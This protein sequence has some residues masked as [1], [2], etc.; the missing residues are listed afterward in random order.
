MAR[1]NWL[2]LD[3]GFRRFGAWALVM[4]GITCA[5]PAQALPIF[6]R[7]TQLACL[8]CHTVYPEL[9]HFGRMFKLNGYQLDN[10]KDITMITDE[11]KQQLALPAVPNLGLFVML[12]DVQLAKSL[13]DSN[14]GGQRSF[15]NGGVE[16]PQQLSLL[17]GGKIAPHFGAFGQVTYDFSADTFNIDNNDFRFANAIVLPDKKPFTYGVSINNNPTI[18]DPWNTTPAFGFPYVPPEVNVPYPAPIINAGTAYEVAGPVAY[19]LWNEQFYAALGV[20]RHAQNGSN[21]PGNAILGEGGPVDSATSGA[22]DGWNP[23]W[24]LAYEYDFDRYTAEVGTYG[25]YFKIYPGNGA[26]LS[27]ATNN[28]TDIAEDFQFQFIGETNTATWKGTFVR[29]NQSLDAT[30]PAGAGTT[31]ASDWLTY[32]STDFTYWYKRKYGFTEGYLRTQGSTDLGMYNFGCYA[33]PSQQVA[34][35]SS[36]ATG[37]SNLGP[38]TSPNNP[39]LATGVINSANGNPATDA[40]VTE[41]MYAP[42]LNLKIVLQYTHYTKFLGAS[43]NYDGVGR[44]AS[45]NDTT[46]LLAWFAM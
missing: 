33:S 22:I 46:Y 45:D 39:L 3:T 26:G 44:N 4:L 23:Y 43:S 9:T 21:S 11:G 34:K 6:A 35:C 40:W 30:G 5:L 37:A 24:R 16:L 36:T 8:A 2:Q 31:N 19:I 14:I 42:W 41:L 10:G 12:G 18:E 27:G 38:Y 17:Y 13:P 32:L 20:Y 25:S 15:S 28:Y 7:Q 1:F 29:E